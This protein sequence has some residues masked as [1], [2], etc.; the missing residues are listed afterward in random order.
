M[1]SL[2]TSAIAIFALFLSVMAQSTTSVLHVPTVPVDPSLTST[3]Y[4]DFTLRV[5]APDSQG[6]FDLKRSDP[7]TLHLGFAADTQIQTPFAALANRPGTVFSLKHNQLIWNNTAT[8]VLRDDF[9]GLG[10]REFVFLI[11]PSDPHGDGF[12]FI[13]PFETLNFTAVPTCDSYG[14]E[15]LRLGRG[16]GEFRCLNLVAKPI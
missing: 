16:D 2:K 14:R 12:L 7:V 8:V 5:L 11:F 6:K 13:E 15:F 9:G 1:Q 10:L 4:K 3:L